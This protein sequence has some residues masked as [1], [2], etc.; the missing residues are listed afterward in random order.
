MKSFEQKSIESYNRKAKDY[1]NTFDG[2]YTESFKKL[3]LDEMLVSPGSSVLDVACGNGKLLQLLSDKYK[4]RAYGI[5]ISDQMIETA[6]RLHPAM[7]FSNGTCEQMPFSDQ[8]FDIITVCAAYHHFPDV[9]G[10]AKEASRVIKAKGFIY[11]ADVY[12]PAVLRVLMNPFFPLSKAGDV[13]MYSP[14]QIMK[15]LE[16]YGFTR[17][18]SLTRETIQL[19]VMQKR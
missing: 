15:N 7:E 8:M 14:E 10:F 19:I 13:R 4:I 5:D 16:K 3:L 17:V 6:K 18:R 1:D 11:I 9:S 2:K 12:Y